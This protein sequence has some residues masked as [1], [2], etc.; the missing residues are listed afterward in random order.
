MSVLKVIMSYLQLTTAIYCKIRDLLR[1][2][3]VF[4]L[5]PIRMNLA[6]LEDPNLDIEDEISL[7]I[8]VQVWSLDLL[9]TFEFAPV[10]MNWAE[11]EDLEFDI[12]DEMS[13]KLLFRYGVQA[14]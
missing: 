3:N 2:V 13:L 14:C 10:Q 12:E 8:V 9:N 4:E 6:E 5:T 11:V 7:V 1:P